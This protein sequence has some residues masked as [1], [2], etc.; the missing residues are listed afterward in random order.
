MGNYRFHDLSLDVQPEKLES[1][2]NLATLFSKL[3][4]SRTSG[5]AAQPSHFSIRLKEEQWKVPPAAAVQFQAAEFCGLEHDDSFYLSY[6]CSA[7]QIQCGSTEAHAY[8]DSSFYSKPD[9]QQH[10]FWSFGLLK[11]LRPSGIYSLHAAGLIA[12]EGEGV[13]I[14]GPSGSGKSTLSLGL[15]RRGWKYLS[16]DGVLLQSK[17]N[18]VQ[19]LALRKYVYID[20]NATAMNQDLPLGEILVDNA[21][22]QKRRVRLEDTSLSEQQIHQSVPSVLLFTRIVREKQSTLTA[23]SDRTALKLL[24]EA[25]APQL[26]DRRTM[27]QHLQ[28]LNALLHQSSKYELRAGYDLFCDA[29]ILFR[30]LTEARNKEATSPVSLSN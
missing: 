9:V 30:L 3:F 4:L 16:D 19:A 5:A 29:S 21:G 26:F 2:A 20:A 27:G 17:R 1:R 6:S 10:N 28:M 11:L 7:F 24:L 8:L 25:S 22:E 18:T 13:L 23:L 14:V 15:I 12:P